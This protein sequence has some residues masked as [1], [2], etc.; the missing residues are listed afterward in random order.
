MKLR[1]YAEYAPSG[2]YWIGRVPKHWETRTLGSL[3]TRI[4]AKKRTDLPLLSV[5]REKG[6][7]LRSSMTADENHNYFPDD[8]SNYQVAPRGALVINKM[9]AWQGSMGISLHE[10]VV[11]PAYFVFRCNFG[12]REYLE[13][14]LRCKLWVGL[15]A[16][17]SDGVRIGQW[18][19]SIDRMRRIPVIVP[20]P[21]EQDAIVCFLNHVDARFNRL[22]RI[23]RRFIALLNEQ[24]QA[25]IHRA[26][27][28]GLDPNVRCKPSGVDWLGDIPE[29]WEVLANRRLFRETTRP[30]AG[31]N[32]PQLS[33]SQRDGL[34]ETDRMKERSLR[35]ASFD[36][37]KICVPGDLVANRFKAHLGV[38][39]GAQVR[40]VV[41]F[42]YGVFR[43]TR[44]VRTKYFELLFHTGPY[45]SIFANASR[46]MTVGLQNLSN[47][48]FYDVKTIVPPIEEQDAILNHVA[49]ETKSVDRAIDLENHEADLVKE[50]RIRLVAD[51]VTGKL[52][53]REAAANLL[54]E[55]PESEDDDAED[56]AGLDDVDDGV[57]EPALADE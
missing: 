31:G 14:Q 37:F 24:R 17:A 20:P 9:K 27:T 5:V 51:I 54:E 13:R 12:N 52:D 48:N 8:L 49:L 7:I 15:F 46:G 29:H 50:Y 10:G 56:D 44:L 11:S 30:Y 55:L 2:T 34:I 32:E 33:L 45:R 28:R 40:G 22:I 21:E 18:D 47:Q 25:I 35:T 26:V 19:L 36:N 43:P 3:L 39:F 16:Q 38:F 4:S 57:G 41:T 23:K 53:I 42:H 6:V 1:P